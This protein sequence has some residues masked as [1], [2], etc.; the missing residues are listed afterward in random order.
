[1]PEEIGGGRNW[2]YRYT[3]I[4]DASFTLYALSRL[5]FQSE[6]QAF[7]HWL[8]DRCKALGP[9]ESLQIMYRI[10][11]RRDLT[12]FLLPHW[13]GYRKSYPVRI[14]NGAQNQLQLDIYGEL[15]DSIYLYD[16]YGEPISYELGLYPEELGIGKQNDYSR[17]RRFL[18]AFTRKQRRSGGETG[19]G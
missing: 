3:W 11:G 2:D 19:H 12:E 9:D 8:E 1:L 4:R 17:L 7:I 6:S 18:P 14:G 10:D 13:Q 16:K 15:M 5:G